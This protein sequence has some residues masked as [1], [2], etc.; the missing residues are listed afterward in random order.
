MESNE[1]PRGI[2]GNK[3]ALI[4]AMNQMAALNQLKDEAERGIKITNEPQPIPFVLN[5]PLPLTTIP[6][7]GKPF[8]K[9]KK[10]NTGF[11]LGSYTYKS[12]RK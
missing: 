11:K 8:Y 1:Q 3:S 2:V 6:D 5:E 12:K 4:L 10:P 7:G 9:D